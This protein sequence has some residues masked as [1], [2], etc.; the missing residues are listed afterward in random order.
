MIIL[1]LE[2]SGPYP[3]EYGIVSIGALEFENPSNTFY[4]ECRLREEQKI[5][6]STVPI[7]GFSEEAMRDPNKKNMGE[8]LQDF[9]EW[10]KTVKEKTFA[11]HNTPFDWTFMIF[12]FRHYGLEWPF[13]VRSVD[14]HTLAYTHMLHRGVQPPR[15]NDVSAVGLS[16]ILEYVGVKDPRKT[17]NALEDAKLEAECLHRLLYGKAL[18]KEYSDQEVPEYLRK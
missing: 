9:L 6:P 8:V 15:L 2:M 4:A 18:L 3:P 16:K 13:N 7:H 10:M 1:D 17:H 12:D 11:A 14:L 5:D